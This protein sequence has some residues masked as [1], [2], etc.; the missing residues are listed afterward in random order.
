MLVIYGWTLTAR[1]LTL[2][3]LTGVNVCVYARW[4]QYGQ[5]NGSNCFISMDLTVA[6]P[7][8]LALVHDEDDAFDDTT[9]YDTPMDAWLVYLWGGHFLPICVWLF[10][11][12]YMVT[13][14]L[15]CLCMP[16]TFSGVD[17]IYTNFH[18][19][20]VFSVD[21]SHAL[22]P[23][24][25]NRLWSFGLSPWYMYFCGLCNFSS[26]FYMPFIMVMLRVY[27]SRCCNLHPIFSHSIA[28][29]YPIF[30]LDFIPNFPFISLTIA[31]FHSSSCSLMSST[32][33]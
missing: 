3:Q 23:C 22:I 15:T 31:D 1:R 18:S 17:T 2:S 12:V 20:I 29:I 32:D 19:N 30:S 26:S 25:F 6:F 7:L 21:L 24:T 5:D 14:A 11:D 13:C 8:P 4:C 27:S 33:L 10:G 28:D 9:L 16:W